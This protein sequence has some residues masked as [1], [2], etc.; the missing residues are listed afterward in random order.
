MRSHL[1]VSLEWKVRELVNKWTAMEEIAKQA[2]VREAN[3]DLLST[4]GL[5]RAVTSEKLAR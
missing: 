2:S 3:H 4:A 1:A 5:C